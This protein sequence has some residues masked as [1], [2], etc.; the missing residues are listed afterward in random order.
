MIPTGIGESQAR[1]LEELKRSGAGTIQEL[2]ERLDLSVETVRSHLKGLAAKDLVERRGQRRRGPGRP[3][4]IYGVTENADPLFPGREG[5]ILQELA[6]FLEDQGHGEIVGRFLEARMA[7]R[8]ESAREC[9]EGLDGDDRLEAVAEILSEEGFM[10]QVDEEEETG[11]TVL[12]LC[13]CPV[14][15]LVAMTKAPCRA[16]LGFV[17]KLLDAEL[18]RVSY[19]PSGD[20]VCAYGLG[21]GH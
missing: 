6:R 12:R 1:I 10:A 13:N 7:E 9:L 15:D 16:E 14:R 19:I 21:T 18:R 17:Q 2:A 5:E 3:E 8:L 20:P 11:E 4:I